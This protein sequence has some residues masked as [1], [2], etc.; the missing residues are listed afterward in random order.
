MTPQAYIIMRRRLS[1]AQ[2]L[3]AKTDITVAD[4]ALKA[5]FADQSH[6][7]RNFHRFTGLP[8]RVFRIQHG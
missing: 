6:F 1:L 3:L 5:G 4:I 2:D 7:S 8:P